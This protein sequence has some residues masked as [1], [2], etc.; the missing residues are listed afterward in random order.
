MPKSERGCRGVAGKLYQ[1]LALDFALAEC[2]SDG[3]GDGGVSRL[4]YATRGTNCA[5]DYEAKA[6]KICFNS[7]ATHCFCSVLLNCLQGRRHI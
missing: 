3:N 6:S 7:I 4:I 1:T 5:T 2:G